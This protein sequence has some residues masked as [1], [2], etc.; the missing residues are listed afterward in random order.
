MRFCLLIFPVIVVFSFSS[1]SANEPALLVDEKF[2]TDALPENWR[3]GGRKD[4]FSIVDGSLRGVAQPDD[5]HGPAISFPISG[6]NITVEFDLKF[7]KPKGYFLFL[8]DGN[9]QFSG[10]AHLLRFAATSKLVHVSQDRGDP[11]S[12]LAQKK[13]RDANGGKRV[14]ATKAQLADPNFYRIEQLANQPA[15]PNDGKWHHVRI[16]I[17]G[18]QVTAQ[19]DK[20]KVISATGTVLDV[21]KSKIVF[22]VGQTGDIRI[23]NVKVTAIGTK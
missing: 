15:T 20:N 9:S 14:P 22:L 7:A 1:L 3:P 10:H 23:D 17:E 13:E 19:L 18:N 16:E 5:S 4:S 21:A 12:K 2:E 8:I 6:K 11:A